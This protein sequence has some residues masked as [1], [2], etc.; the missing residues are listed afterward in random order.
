MTLFLFIPCFNCL[1]VRWLSFTKKGPFTAIPRGA[2]IS[3]E[4]G[5]C[6]SLAYCFNPHVSARTPQHSSF[7]SAQ[8]FACGLIRPQTPQLYK[9]GGHS[10]TPLQ[11]LISLELG[12]SGSVADIFHPL[13]SGR[14]LNNE[15]PSTPLRTSARGLN[16]AKTPQQRS[17]DFAQDFACGARTP[18]KTAQLYKKRASFR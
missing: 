6:G 15:D 7:D 12:C 5:A 10:A 13:H 17:F 2:L 14:R 8:D 11:P 4:L 16:A 9:N 3:Q 18:R 1:Q